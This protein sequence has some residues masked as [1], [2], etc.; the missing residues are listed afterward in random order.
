ML[1][2]IASIGAE[3]G[4]LMMFA[5]VV[6]FLLCY[7]I[8]ISMADWKEQKAMERAEKQ[9]DRE[10]AIATNERY[11]QIIENQSRQIERSTI[12]I[13]GYQTELRK[14]TERS[15]LSFKEVAGKL[16]DLDDKVKI[17]G[18]HSEGLATKEMV[19]DVS[20][21]IRYIKDSLK[22]D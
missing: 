7:I 22:K 14:H 12:S 9:K 18:S 3:Q 15:D 6:L 17:I 1:E 2:K 5:I 11:A 13:Q 4:F 8:H 21:D 16:D 20:D 19:A 10:I